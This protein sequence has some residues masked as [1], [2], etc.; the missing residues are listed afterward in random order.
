MKYVDCSFNIIKIYG[1]VIE[2]HWNILICPLKIIVCFIDDAMEI[3][4]I[5]WFFIKQYWNSLRFIECF[6]EI[7][8]LLLNWHRKSLKYIDL[9]LQITEIYCVLMKLIVFYWFINGK[10][11]KYI[12]V[13]FKCIKM[14]WC[15]L[16]VHCKSL[17]LLIFIEN[18]WKLLMFHWK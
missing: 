14:H 13:S 1:F 4:E 15:L 2:N 3:I 10:S 7:H 18:N 9:P 12:D 8:C 16:I 17:F 11:L 6:I 5:Y